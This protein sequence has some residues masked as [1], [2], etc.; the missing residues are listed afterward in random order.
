M[1]G[2][3]F[4]KLIYEFLVDRPDVLIKGRFLVAFIPSNLNSQYHKDQRATE[5]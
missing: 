1:R 2:K 5:G 4:F 3:A